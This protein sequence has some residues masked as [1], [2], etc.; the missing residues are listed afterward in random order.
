[1]GGLIVLSVVASVLEAFGISMVLP[2][3]SGLLSGDSFNDGRIQNLLERSG[4]ETLDTFSILVLIT[5]VFF[6]KGG[7]S[8]A[9]GLLIPR[10]AIKIEEDI[11]RTLMSRI[12]D[13]KWEIFHQAEIGRFVNVLNKESQAIVT[14]TKYF[15]RFIT[16]LAEAVILVVISLFLSP[17]LVGS[18]IFFGLFAVFATH[19]LVKKTHD[20]RERWVEVDN[21]L[22][23]VVIEN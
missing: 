8:F 11:R 10:L 21:R 3:F 16:D 4:L 5:A 15:C 6:I 14:A 13:A 9:I 23:S 22:N 12:L 1:M 17:L 2:V 20:R 18:G 7:F 19:F